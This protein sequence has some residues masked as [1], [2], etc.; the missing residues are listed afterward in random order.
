MIVERV[1]VWDQR[2]LARA[3]G[4]D[5]GKTQKGGLQEPQGLRVAASRGLVC[6]AW[7][8]L[9]DADVA[10]DP[11]VQSETTPPGAQPQTPPRSAA[12]TTAALPPAAGRRLS[13][14]CELN[15][16]AAK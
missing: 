4:E 12:T 9:G 3:N 1:L 14:L 15:S 8:P 16:Q 2:V 10:E 13:Q 6:Q 11:G 7:L 5:R